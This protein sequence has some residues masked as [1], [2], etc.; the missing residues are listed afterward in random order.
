M[1]EIEEQALNWMEFDF[2]KSKM[3]NLYKDAYL[4]GFKRGYAQNKSFWNMGNTPHNTDI[5]LIIVNRDDD[6]YRF[7]LGRYVKGM[8]SIEPSLSGWFELCKEF[9]NGKYTY[10]FIPL[11]NEE[12]VGWAEIPSMVMNNG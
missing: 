11:E 2:E 6:M 9:Q 10:S 8:E 1:K 3:R 4:S 7:R 5:V 12:I